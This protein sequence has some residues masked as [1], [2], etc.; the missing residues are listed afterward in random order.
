M[1]LSGEQ[2]LQRLLL[3]VPPQRM[4]TVRACGLYAS[5]KTEELDRCRA[6]LGQA[7]VEKPAKIHWHEA[8]AEHNE[9]H[10]ECCPV[11]GKRLIRGE[12]IPPIKKKTRPVRVRA[13]APPL[14]PPD[15][16]R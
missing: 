6:L 2:F 13:H 4:Q 5:T 3:H 10:P 14:L 1:T 16:L 11:C 12:T 7:P 15:L 9:D 8:C